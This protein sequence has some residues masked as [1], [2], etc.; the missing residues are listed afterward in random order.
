[1]TSRRSPGGSG[2]DFTGSNTRWLVAY[3]RNHMPTGTLDAVL[4]AAGERRTPE[5]LSDEATWS[6]YDEFRAMLEATAVALGGVEVLTAIGLHSFEALAIPDYAEMLQALGSP[7]ALYAELSTA[8]DAIYPIV[9]VSSEEATATE[10]IVR[11][12]LRD[13]REPFKA[14]CWYVRG[15]LGVTPRLFGFPAAE[16]VE[17]ECA[18]SGAAACVFHIRWEPIEEP[19]RRAEYWETR[20]VVLEA[21]LDALQRT[22]AD[23]VSGDELP[24]VLSRIVSSAA[25]AVQAPCFVLV[26]DALPW[27]AER[28]HAAG[29]APRDARRIAAEVTAA[30]P[31]ADPSR[32]VIDV[33][34]TLRSYGRLAA[35]KAP[36]DG[37]LPQELAIL[38]AYGRLAAA[39]LDSAC[40]LEEA[41]A[42]LEL[43]MRLAEVVS[44]EEMAVKL[45]QAVSA[46]IDCDCAMVSLMEPGEASGVIAAT[47]GFAPAV[48]RQLVGMSFQLGE[49]PHSGEVSYRSAS[50]P[51]SAAL[52][53]IFK[54]SG[55]V[56]CAW[57]PIVS[58]GEL[59]G[60]IAAGV[61]SHPE[62]LS[63]SAALANRMR[64]L[65]AQAATAIGNARLL[66]HVRHQALHD[67]LTGLPN[68]A[69]ILDRAEQM[70]AR[71]ERDHHSV[72]ALFIDVDNFK[73]VNDTLGHEAGDE[74]LRAIAARLADALR[75]SDTIGRMGGDEFVVLT[76]GLP[77]GTGP[78]L[79]AER[80]HELMRD[81]FMLDAENGSSL[82]VSASVGICRG[83]AS[84]ASELLRNADIALYRAKAAGKNCSV[85]FESAMQSEVVRRLQLEMDLQAILDDQLFVLYQPLFDL[86][87][88]QATGAEALLRWRHPTHGVL[89]PAEFVPLLERTGMISD[90]GRFVLHQACAQAARW[91]RA[92]VLISIAV[93]V[94]VHQLDSDSLV[95]DVRDAL[96]TAELDAD[97]L[98]IEITE[99]ALMQDTEVTKLRLTE[100]KRLG[101][102]LAIDDFG[103]GYSSLA[104]LKQFPM[105]ILKIDRSFVAGLGESPEAGA[106]VHT[107]VQLGRVLGLETLAEG[108]ENH[109]QLAQLQQE[110]CDSG[111]GFLLCRPME[112]H[113]LEQFFSDRDHPALMP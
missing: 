55:V 109:A 103:T 64:G 31:D 67:G 14:F 112:A 19:L 33:A 10:W 75:G 30:A 8:T 76:E 105:D 21:R 91:R 102:R 90:V 60:H 81:P 110:R 98:V 65:A 13:G 44:A 77:A 35:I 68:R 36:G 42:L 26:L 49:R 4:Q 48:E 96:K 82:R 62:R 47:S 104:Y 107:L 88:L 27:V 59:V 34:S 99:T 37:F 86:T 32:L 108:I 92:G 94:S 23:L 74:L 29:L 9:E 106:L 46:V 83:P 70:L 25:R 80:V 97:A 16:I 56:T 53:T 93:N 3:L 7:A 50:A 79:V 17:D 1:V 54:L 111:Q 52:A 11:C 113:A 66:D 39:A 2:R 6:T 84:S 28:V 71:A 45:S 95:Q 100:L 87:T 5:Q 73:D 38:E 69:L 18:C 85:V 51:G 101:V 22:V 78:E 24:G 89:S 72:A 15:L 57:L 43:S 58:K 20:S 40:A 61:R 63:G 12:R 41:R